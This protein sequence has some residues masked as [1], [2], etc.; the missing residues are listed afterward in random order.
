MD[1]RD[2]PLSNSYTY[3]PSPLV[4]P[5]QAFF[6]ARDVGQAPTEESNTPLSFRLQI[7]SWK[8]NDCSEY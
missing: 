8:K 5:I 7:L 4:P 2:L 3:G 6:A 1:Q